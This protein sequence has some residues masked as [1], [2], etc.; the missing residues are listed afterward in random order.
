MSAELVVDLES[1][2]IERVGADLV[3]V[4]F[5]S[6]ERP[7]RDGAG[8]ADWR[9]CGRLSELLAEGRLRGERGEAALLPSFGSLRAPVLLALGLGARSAF[10]AP[11]CREAACE[12]VARALKLGARVVA[13]ELPGTGIP[14]LGLAQRAEALL[15]GAAESLAER[16]GALRLRVIAPGEPLGRAID[17]LRH[18]RPR[19]LPP[20]LVLRLPGRGAGKPGP[21][22][23]DAPGESR[24]LV[25]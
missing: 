9:L 25:K 19:P 23:P 11:A 12:A 8:R 22:R 4:T 6:S 10:G 16:P 3:V 13:L 2:P 17:V 14:G 20:S 21:G 24:P 15:S 1:E 7:L 18:A 5:F